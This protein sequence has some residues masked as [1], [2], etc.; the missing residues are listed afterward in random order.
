MSSEPLEGISAICVYQEG[1]DIDKAT[2][3]HA[4]RVLLVGRHK[5]ITDG[6]RALF[7]GEANFRVVGQVADAPATIDA[8]GQLKPDVV[9]LDLIVQALD[10]LTTIGQIK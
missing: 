4:T 3:K 2:M 5:L 8:I 6:L 1:T 7:E 9:V 10:S